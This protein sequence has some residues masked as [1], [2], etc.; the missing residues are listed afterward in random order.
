VPTLV[1]KGTA[2]KTGAAS[3]TPAAVTL[4]YPGTVANNDIFM[5]QVI[6]ATISGQT[7]G[8][9]R[10]PPGGRRSP[11][12]AFATAAPPHVGRWGGSGNAATGRKPGP[13]SCSNHVQLEQ[14]VGVP[15]ADLPDHRVPHD[16]HPVGIG[17][18]VAEP[19][20]VRP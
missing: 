5:L 1:S 8:R 16:R 3:G 19:V 17:H 4:A 12:A 2:S 14:R 7:I 13:F 15:R 20:R 6:V 9:S 10:R 18:A 11:R